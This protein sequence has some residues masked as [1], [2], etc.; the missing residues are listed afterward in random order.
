MEQLNNKLLEISSNKIKIVRNI[1]QLNNKL[2]EISSNY[3]I[4][5]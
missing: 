5:C 4:N 1:E 2:L 3:I